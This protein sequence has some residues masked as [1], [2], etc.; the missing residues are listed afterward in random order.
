MSKSSG[1]G[2]FRRAGLEIGEFFT[3]HGNAQ[4]RLDSDAKKE[5]PL[6]GAKRCLTD[7]EALRGGRRLEIDLIVGHIQ[8]CQGPEHELR[9]APHFD[10]S[11][12]RGASLLKPP[13][14]STSPTF[15]VIDLRPL[16][17]EHD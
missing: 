13:L 6:R 4:Y 8:I 15:H 11:V 9:Q 5:G 16:N 12:L 2:T 3:T 17:P 1:G 14:P 7:P 10:H